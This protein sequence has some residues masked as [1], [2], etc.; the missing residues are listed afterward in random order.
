MDPLQQIYVQREHYGESQLRHGKTILVEY[1]SPN[2][3]K[4]F[5]VGHLRSTVIGEF[6]ANLFQRHGATVVRINYLGD[7]G[8]QFGLLA[9]GFLQLGREDALEAD[10][11]G[12]LYT[13]YVMINAL[14]RHNKTIHAQARRFVRRMESGD[15][16]TLALWQRLRTLSLERYQRVYDQLNVRFDVIEGEAQQHKR[17][18][19]VLQLFDDKGLLVADTD[20]GGKV[21][22]LGG[23]LGN[24]LLQKRDGTTIYLTRDVAAALHRYERYHFDAMYYV[25]SDQQTHHFQQLF[26]LLHKLNVP[27]ASRCH[28]IGYGLVKGM[29]TRKGNTVFL[30]EVLAKAKATMYQK[31]VQD[32]KKHVTANKLGV[33]HAVGLSAVMI[34]DLGAKRARGYR[35]D[36]DRM[37]HY[38]GCT[39][40][41]LQYAHARLCSLERR[42]ADVP[43]VA[44]L[45]DSLL[46]EP[47][48][49][50]LIELVARYPTVVQTALQTLESYALCAYLFE[51]SRA[52]A[53]ALNTLWVQ[54]RAAP[55][56][57]ARKRLYWS[58]RIVMGNGLRLLGLVPLEAM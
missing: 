52:V 35:F 8:K 33:A 40:P 17:A 45:D 21:V 23:K 30:T 38:K 27:F 12:H 37:L 15:A 2:I 41:N 56:Q 34:Q 18:L 13:V 28:H 10:P 24:A 7:W 46:Q 43:L 49:Q 20:N 54:G 5:H 22:A 19:Q 39:G 29:S 32:A 50:R 9:I 14:A 26:A 48:A 44:E 3:A 1:S 25:V 31:M 58:A 42:N 55:L 36:W 53:R 47:E 6:L 4:P 11:L 16:Q 51:V 57:R